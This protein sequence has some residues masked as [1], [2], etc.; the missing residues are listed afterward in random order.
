[1]SDDLLWKVPEGEHVKLKEYD[2]DYVHPSFKHDEADEVLA[3]LGR[4]MDELQELLA[5]AQHHSLLM[6][7]QGMDTSGKDG[8]IRHVFSNMNPQGCRVTSFK[9]PTPEE[10]AHDFLWRINNAAP[11]KGVIGVFNRSQYED[12]LVV[13]VHNL[14]PEDVWKRRYKEIN[15]FEKRLAD[16]GTIILKFFLH[17]SRDEQAERLQAR[18][19]EKDKAWKISSSDFVERQY[20]DDY[21]QAYEDALSQCSTDEAP[22]Y[23]VPANHKWYRNLAIAQTLVDTMRKYKDEWK[24]DLEERGRKELEAL[25]QLRDSGKFNGL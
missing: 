22:W 16:N 2:P 10:A 14:V 17:I 3:Q 18:V 12:V 19:D 20:W 9:V 25:Q 23:I 8:T 6:V 7:L 21:Q 4:E 5:A 24:A 15:H 11:P 1:M 13:R